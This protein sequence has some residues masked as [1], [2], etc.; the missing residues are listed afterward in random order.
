MVACPPHSGETS[1]T[2]QGVGPQR[3][4][5]ITPRTSGDG[6]HV[7]ASATPCDHETADAMSLREWAPHLTHR[8]R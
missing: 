4:Q 1:A 3:R 5:P 6:L 8:L 7:D 2:L